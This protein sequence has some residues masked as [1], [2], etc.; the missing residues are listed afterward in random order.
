[1][2]ELKTLHE[3]SGSVGAPPFD[4]L[5]ETARKRDRRVVA[6]AVASF[7]VLAVVVAG[8]LLVDRT[9]RSAPP[10]NDPRP[11]QP[12]YTPRPGEVIPLAKDVESASLAKGRYAVTMD[13]DWAYEVDVPAGWT[14]IDGK[15][16]LAPG[17]PVFVASLAGPN[18][19]TVRTDPCRDDTPKLVGPTVDDLASALR[20]QP[21]LGVGTPAP[22]TIG[23]AEGVYLEVRTPGNV[24]YASCAG[25]AVDLFTSGADGWGW[26]VQTTVRMWIL[27]WEGSRVVFMS[28][29]ATEDECT[30]AE[31]E[32]TKA[33]AES[34]SFTQAE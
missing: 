27:E 22:V 23:G 8:G 33:M 15:Y 25:G 1:M 2:P 5:V 24:D 13:P 10:V 14:V 4:S 16:L 29:C 9:D 34:V 30:A 19:T 11:A 21:V 26:T 20:G 18:A 31:V 17:G 32:T 12:T 28:Q 7:A 3:L 6:T